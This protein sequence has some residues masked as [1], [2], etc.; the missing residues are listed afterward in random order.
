MNVAV[1]SARIGGIERHAGVGVDARRH[2]ERQDRRAGARAPLDQ[3]GVF[4]RGRAREADAE[5]AVDDQRRRRPPEALRWVRDPAA[6]QRGVRGGGV[7]R[8]PRDVAAKDDVDVEERLREAA[9]DDE[10]VAAVVPGTGEH[11][12]RTAASRGHRARD[13]APP[14]HR[15]APSARGPR[16][17][18]RR[19]AMPATAQDEPSVAHR[20]GPYG[21][22]DVGIV[23]VRHNVAIECSG[24]RSRR[25]AP[26]DA[27]NRRAPAQRFR[28]RPGFGLSLRRPVKSVGWARPEL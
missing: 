25:R 17:A 27:V 12:D 22:D 13:L 20:G 3:R 26:A 9:R 8:Q 10:R 18:P 15:R 7:R 28:S 11:D 4:R 6:A 23:V 1:A 24:T 5:Q 2:V 14:R 21:H 16:G 19:R